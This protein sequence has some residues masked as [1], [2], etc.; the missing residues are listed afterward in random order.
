MG[1]FSPSKGLLCKNWCFIQCWWLHG[2]GLQF[3]TA[4][5]LIRTLFT[6]VYF[7]LWPTTVVC[8]HNNNKSPAV[9]STAQH[10][11]VLE[12]FILQWSCQWLKAN[13]RRYFGSVTLFVLSAYCSILVP[14]RSELLHDA[15]H[16]CI[17]VI[18]ASCCQKP[19]QN[20]SKTWF[21]I[22]WL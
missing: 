20:C 14:T 12:L 16:K 9:R 2:F 4:L 3:T 13:L 6:C 21:V 17:F 8:Q 22:L 11:S 19:H 18:L 15:C 10:L 5:S 7:Y 1:Y